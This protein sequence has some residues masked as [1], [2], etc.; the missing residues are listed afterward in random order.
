MQIRRERRQQKEE[1]RVLIGCD[2]SNH[3]PSDALILRH[4][5]AFG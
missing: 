4:R 1:E 2:K 5:S 3:S